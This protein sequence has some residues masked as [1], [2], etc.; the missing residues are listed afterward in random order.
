MSEAYAT[1]ASG[2]PRR[3]RRGRASRP[4]SGRR[5]EWAFK[6]GGREIGHL[7]G[8]HAAHFFFPRDLWRELRWEGRIVEH[9]VF[10]QREGPAARPIA[11]EDDV[12]EVIELLR[13]N[14]DHVLAR[15]AG[16]RVSVAIV[17][18]A[19]RG[20]GLELARELDARGWTVVVDARDGD[21]LAAATA[22]LERVIALPG[23]VADARHRA[24]LVAAAGPAHR[25]DRQQREPPRSE[26][27]T[28]PRRIS[29]RRAAPRLRGQRA[30]AARADPGGA[31]AAHRRRGDR[32]RDVGRRRRGVCR[33]GWLWLLEGRARAAH[34]GPRRGASATC[35]C[36]RS[37]RATCGRRCTRTRS[38]ARTSPTARPPRR[39][40][41]DSSR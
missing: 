29:A 10:P 5:G 20:L 39:A 11:D 32:Q 34:G 25:S 26:P 22:G 2:S 4:G 7:H 14:Y 23:D 13:L 8:D 28:G 9:P 38:R 36:S 31:A 19:S 18:G 27:A 30:R 17:T 3:S 1:R 35:G 21:A 33:L 41:R 24:E 16:A 6:V 12:R 40:C 37:T 15:A